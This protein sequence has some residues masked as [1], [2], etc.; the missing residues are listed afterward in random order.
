MPG[1]GCGRLWGMTRVRETTFY[2]VTCLAVIA[3]TVETIASPAR[4]VALFAAAATTVAAL[5]S[6][7]RAAVACALSSMLLLQPAVAGAGHSRLGVAI[8]LLGALFSGLQDARR[9]G[10]R[11]ASKG[12][13]ALLIWLGLYALWTVVELG[14]HPGVQAAGF[15]TNSAILMLVCLPAAA[16]ILRDPWRRTRFVQGV[17]LTMVAFAIS[18]FVTM[19]LIGA[20]GS[21]AVVG[22]VTPRG[23]G[24][25]EVLFPFTPVSGQRDILG[26]TVP[27]LL[28]PLR[29]PGLCQM[30]FLWSFFMAPRVGMKNKWLSRALLFG[31]LATQS[32]TGF[33]IL[34]V[35]YVGRF[36]LEAPRT[37]AFPLLAQYFGAFALAA[38]AYLA[39]IAPV[40]GVAAKQDI[41]SA[42]ISDRYTNS[43]VGLNSLVTQPLGASAASD[44]RNVG[45][46]ALSAIF[47]VGV[48]GIA[49]VCFAY[50]R[51]A[52]AA[53]L[54]AKALISVMPIFIT[55]LVAQPILDAEGAWTLVLASSLPYVFDGVVD[56]R[57]IDKSEAPGSVRLR[58]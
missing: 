30:V 44:G 3:G 51:P 17:I 39:V 15:V 54:G 23:Y 7:G 26:R 20:T 56:E 43:L 9:P 13:R 52:I 18:A 19:L 47:F 22:H 42:S 6:P 21:A 58:L 8:M 5:A 50:L 28:G 32:T 34:L 45:I 14:L 25:Q 10:Q 37:R 29:E 16:L 53:G 55:S 38:A 12:A 40:V 46:N 2:G 11:Q 1:V 35:V 48:P 24:P 27:R 41:N 31:V 4:G 36:I 33:A 49:L 57:V